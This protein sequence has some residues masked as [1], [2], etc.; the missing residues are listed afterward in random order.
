MKEKKKW[1]PKVKKD[2]KPM[3]KKKFLLMGF[4]VLFFLMLVAAGILL[5]RN[6]Q[7][8][9]P[10]NS[11]MS[12]GSDSG[13]NPFQSGG[14]AGSFGN[15]NSTSLNSVG[16]A[17]TMV[18]ASG[19][20]SMG[21][22]SENF[23]V[24]D[25]TTGLYVE[26]VYV[27]SGEK[28]EEGTALLKLSEDSVAEAK[29]ELEKAKTDTDLAYRAGVI[30]YQQNLINIQYDY[31]AAVLAGEQAKAVYE[32]N[33]SRLSEDVERAQ[34][35]LDEAKEL[36]AEY[37]AAI[38]QDTYATTYPY[39]E[40]KALYDE[41]LEVLKAKIEEWG[42]SWE[43][44]VNGRGGNQYETVL[45]GLYSVLEQNLRDY[46]EAKENYDNAV[47]EAGIQLKKQQLSLSSLETD[48][49]NAKKEEEEGYLS[50]KLTYETALAEAEQ[51][52]ENY[53][54]ALEQAEAEYEELLDAKE[55]AE[56]NLALFEETVGD[57][58]FYASESG[59]ILRVNCR[60]G[61]YLQ[62][63]S[64]VASYSDTSQVTVTVSVSQESIAAIAV[65]DTA[66][67]SASD[68][69]MW[70]AYVTEINPV[71][72]AE[73]RTSVTYS[74]TIRLSGDTSNVSANTQVTVIFGMGGMTNEKDN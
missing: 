47:E 26:E 50:A 20:T 23:E 51:A 68:G 55:K 24:T 11:W 13:G 74:V 32:E 30:E 72:S 28:V 19:V 52:K 58:Y 36:I 3:S 61:S 70:Q 14:F 71:S 67:V 63:D 60:R 37:E 33:I 5:Y 38:T 40:L 15:G 39:A 54:A 34:E 4:V 41:N 1:Q 44:V 69:S 64:T 49:A 27:S 31:D 12:F 48:L 57:G 6:G 9:Q 25:M 53:E 66:M 43:R 29:A 45:Q 42:V 73:S 59:S 21:V 2:K 46:E 35:A 65:G 8:R 10:D 56:E 62:A 7:S 22:I 16:Q 17:A 18:S